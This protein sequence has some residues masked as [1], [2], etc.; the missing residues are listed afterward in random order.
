MPLNIGDKAPDF[1]L[2]N[3]TLNKI[4]LSDFAGKTVVLLF[5][6]MDFSPVCTQEHRCVSD[7]LGSLGLND[8]TVVFG[9]NCDHAFSHA[10]FKKEYKIQYDLLSDTSR[11]TVKAYDMFSGVEPFNCAKRGTVVIDPDGRIKSITEYSVDEPR[12]PE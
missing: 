9:I 10:A 3:Q 7:S 12:T 6:P 2:M 4:K 1:E 5:Y 11:E 8:N